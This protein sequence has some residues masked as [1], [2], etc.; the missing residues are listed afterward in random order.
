MDL[1]LNTRNEISCIVPPLKLVK[2]EMATPTLGGLRS[3][4]D[5]LEEQF[6][7]EANTRDE[8]RTMRLAAKELARVQCSRADAPRRAAKSA[9]SSDYPMATT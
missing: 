8:A 6:I 2:V 5:Y 3:A 1:K 9:K 4:F 7:T